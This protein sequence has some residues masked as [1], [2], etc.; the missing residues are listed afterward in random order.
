MTLQLVN[1][2]ISVIEKTQCTY[3]AIQ[4]LLPYCDI[5]LDS[6]IRLKYAIEL[7][8]CEFQHSS[9]K[10]PKSCDKFKVYK[11]C[12]TEL[13][14]K[15][16]WWTTYSGNYK[17]VGQICNEFRQHYEIQ[18]IL[19]HH[20]NSTEFAK[21]VFNHLT[22]ALDVINI[23]NIYN[24][25]TLNSL[26]NVISRTN[27]LNHQLYQNYLQNFQLIHHLDQKISTS[28][29]NL[30]NLDNSITSQTDSLN[31]FLETFAVTL[32]NMS[33]YANATN[34]QLSEILN[35]SAALALSHQNLTS[36]LESNLAAAENS[37]TIIKQS[38]KQMNKFIN[39]LID[40]SSLVELFLFKLIIGC[41][42]GYICLTMWNYG[43]QK[44]ALL[45]S[46][47]LV[48]LLPHSLAIF[49]YLS[50]FKITTTK[51]SKFKTKSTKKG[52]LCIY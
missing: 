22:N 9:I 34:M 37:T 5:T 30:N 42:G 3:N 48:Y 43:F 40:F 18:N 24:N 10:Y 13:E 36:A 49:I 31:K 17:F 8:K 51:V 45:I 25:S 19:E 32:Q 16:Q 26:E 12:T 23:N 46:A 39:S 27:D 2:S 15:P 29:T 44:F 28:L 1:N 52:N 11:D 7:S 41:G 6:N 33:I 4:N 38:N 47:V 14:K 50:C 20:Q 21:S 35:S